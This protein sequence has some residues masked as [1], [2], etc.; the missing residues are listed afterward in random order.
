MNASSEPIVVTI[1]GGRRVI[2]Q[3]GRHAL[4]T[5]QPVENGGEDSGI[6][7]FDAFLASLGACAG[8]FVQGFCA[9]RGIPTDEIQ[10][11]ERPSYGPDG[12]LA[13]VDFEV[14]LPDG[15]PAKYREPVLRAVEQCSVKRA[16]AA[17]PTF[18]VHT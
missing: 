4:R 3:V 14:K 7:P 10:I 12:V 5:D 2:A 15:F 11:L 17:A 8:V 6:S 13:G 1:P 18:T 9:H 16:I